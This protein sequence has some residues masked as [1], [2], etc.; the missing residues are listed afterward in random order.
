MHCPICKREVLPAAAGEKSFVP[1]CSE[2]CKLVDF[3]R[4]WQGKYVVVEDVDLANLPPDEYD[5]M[6]DEE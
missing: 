2:R 6:R 1:F 5:L 3:Q 4:W